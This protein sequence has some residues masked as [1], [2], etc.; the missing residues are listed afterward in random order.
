MTSSTRKGETQV[1]V[2]VDARQV[3]I[4]LN[5][6]T[7]LTLEQYFPQLLE[8]VDYALNVLFWGI[9][10]CWQVS[11]APVGSNQHKIWFEFI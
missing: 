3:E 2:G 10:E 11:I 5:D 8:L 1:P 9:R 7:S 4:V 6:L